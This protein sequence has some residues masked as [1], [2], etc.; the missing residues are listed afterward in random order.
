[1]NKLPTKDAIRQWITENPG[2]VAKRDIAKA[3]GV[4]GDARIDLKRMLAE[5]EE[6][7]A[8]E[9]RARCRLASRPLSRAATRMPSPCTHRSSARTPPTPY[10]EALPITSLPSRFAFSAFPAPEVPL[11]A[12]TR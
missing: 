5:L 10:A 11:A 12:T 8:L 6:E 4:K 7:G 3:F 1:M 9:K 2:L